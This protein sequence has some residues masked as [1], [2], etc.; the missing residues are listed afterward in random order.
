MA[1]VR[2]QPFVDDFH[3]LQERVNRL[4]ADTALPHLAGEDTMGAWSPLC[5]IYEDDESIQVKAE[6]PGV[7]RND[8]DIQVENN[9]L[10][11]KGERK[12]DREVKSDN[13]YRTERFYGSFTRSFTLPVSVDSTRIKAE[14]REGVL[15]LTLPKAEEAKPRKIK[16]LT[17]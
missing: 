14:Y 15:H 2:F 5:D 4:F 6:L 13:V 3:G 17:S 10:T 12:R 11:L 8:I 16:I 1:L 9:V 7:D